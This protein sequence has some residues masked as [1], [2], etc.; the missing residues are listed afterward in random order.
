MLEFQALAELGIPRRVLNRRRRRIFWL[1]L[2]RADERR[3][4]RI[5]A[6]RVE[7]ELEAAQDVHPAASQMTTHSVRSYGDSDLEHDQWEGS[8]TATANTKNSSAYRSSI[9]CRVPADT[10][11]ENRRTQSLNHTIFVFLMLSIPAH[12]APTLE[13]L[14][15]L[16][17]FLRVPR[18]KSC[19]ASTAFRNDRIGIAN[20]RGS[21][22]QTKLAK[23]LFWFG[24]CSE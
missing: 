9:S 22:L 17:C 10:E 15:F 13:K 5:E 24:R 20:V 8:Y 12:V 18:H 4:E 7:G 3:H 16:S 1:K 2:R 6:L 23:L 19:I 21:D 14:A 11:R